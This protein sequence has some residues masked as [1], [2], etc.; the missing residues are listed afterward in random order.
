MRGRPLRTRGR[1]GRGTGAASRATKI[2]RLSRDSPRKSARSLNKPSIP[3]YAEDAFDPDAGGSVRATYQ[4]PVLTVSGLTEE[5]F[6]RWQS[7]Y[8]RS[9]EARYADLDDYENDLA[10]GSAA[11]RS[12]AADNKDFADSLVNGANAEASDAGDRDYYATYASIGLDDDANIDDLLIGTAEVDSDSDFEI[13]WIQPPRR[14]FYNPPPMQ[15]RRRRKR[16]LGTVANGSHE[17]V[18]DGSAFADESFIGESESNSGRQSRRLRVKRGGANGKEN[19]HS[20]IVMTLPLGE[21]DDEMNDRWSSLLGQGSTLPPIR[22]PVPEASLDP[23]VDED[24]EPMELVDEG[25]LSDSDFPPPFLDRLSTP[26]EADCE[27]A[28]D[29]LVKT[30]FAPLANPQIFIQA[31]NKHPPESRDSHI[32][33]ELAL[34]TQ[35]ALKAWQ[36]EYLILDARTAPHANPPKRPVIAARIPAE[37]EVYEDQ[38]E[39]DLYDYIYDPKK[40]PGCQDPFSQRVGASEFVGGREL[41]QRRT[42]RDVG[43]DATEDEGVLTDIGKRARRAVQRYDGELGIGLVGRKRVGE[44]RTPERDETPSRKRGR[45][46]AAERAAM[47]HQNIRRLR[48]E[49]TVTLTA[50]EAETASPEPSLPK[51][52]GRPPGSKNLAPRSDAGVKKGPRKPKLTSRPSESSVAGIES[53]TLEG[54]GSVPRQE[55]QEAEVD[56]HQDAELSEAIMAPVAR[57][58]SPGGR[59]DSA[60]TSSGLPKR[61]QR[62][63]SEKRSQ[64]MTEWWA[65]RK[66]KMQKE[67]RQKAEVE[68]ELAKQQAE[69]SR[70]GPSSR[71][72][73]EVGARSK[74]HVF[75]H[76][77]GT[78]L[79]PLNGPPLA[80][81]PPLGSRSQSSIVNNIPPVQSTN[82]NDDSSSPTRLVY[83]A[84]EPY[85]VLQRTH[86]M[87]YSRPQHYSANEFSSALQAP[88]TVAPQR[89]QPPPPNPFSANVQF[90]QYP[91]QSVFRPQSVPPLNTS[92]RF[93]PMMPQ[94]AQA[95]NAPPSFGHNHMGPTLPNIHQIQA[96]SPVQPTL[97]HYLPHAYPPAA[98]QFQLSHYQP[99]PP[100][101]SHQPHQLL[102]YP[103]VSHGL[104]TL[105]P[106]PG[107]TPAFSQQVTSQTPQGLPALQPAPPAPPPSGTLS[108]GLPPAHVFQPPY[109]GPQQAQ[110]PPSYSHHHGSYVQHRQP[111]RQHQHIMPSASP[112]LPTD[113]DLDPASLPR[114]HQRQRSQHH[115]HSRDGSF[116]STNQ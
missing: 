63:K 87:Q 106:A 107:P 55:N 1:V 85:D 18:A 89:S 72:W 34:N 9:F 115:T 48:E 68:K 54:S 64:S 70:D 10:A 116:A 113:M 27:D 29:F 22:E 60:T 16:G 46:S 112:R 28:A 100:S 12:E 59:I 4:R 49:S 19:S 92:Q 53:D 6:E 40:P 31:L 56:A 47:I 86:D 66:A 24:D 8:E 20:T 98:P 11:S 50:S 90:G 51:R 25:A 3:N 7:D 109:M 75:A 88:N 41:R 80:P 2:S 111:P 57:T 96:H 58:D 84:K 21:V 37:H 93:P 73:D 108:A 77:D 110:S 35:R 101:P 81:A 39:A 103:L 67:K 82:L 105:A 17:N 33:Y 42:A 94:S 114:E 97:P 23:D 30:R 102:Q 74:T 61:K 76:A 78:T 91:G 5:D 45:P 71:R 79:K 13:I 65:A 52:R 69:R 83:G 99:P 32:L 44:P 14:G 38:K 62:V 95:N 26:D 104:P 43:A 15:I 36:D